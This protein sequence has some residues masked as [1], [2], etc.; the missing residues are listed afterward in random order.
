[1]SRLDLELQ[2]DEGKWPTSTGLQVS[3]TTNGAVL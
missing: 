2:E 3:V 1:M